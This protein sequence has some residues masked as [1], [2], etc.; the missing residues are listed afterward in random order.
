MLNLTKELIFMKCYHLMMICKSQLW[1]VF[2]VLLNHDL[3]GMHHKRKHHTDAVLWEMMY[4]P[5][6]IRS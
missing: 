4:P 5:T 2:K 6:E 1:D 3:Y